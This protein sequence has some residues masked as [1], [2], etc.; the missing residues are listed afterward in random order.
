MANS[1]LKDPPEP[2]PSQANY[3]LKQKPKEPTNLQK[4]VLSVLNLFSRQ[5]KPLAELHF[6][7][8]LKLQ[9]TAIQLLNQLKTI[10]DL[11]EH[12]QDEELHSY[13]KTVICTLDQN[14]ASIH[15]MTKEKKDLAR[16]VKAYELYA[17]WISEARPWIALLSGGHE[18]D[19]IVKISAGYISAE[20]IER[21]IRSIRNYPS[22]QLA[23]KYRSLLD[24][25]LVIPLRKLEGLK[26]LPEDLSIKE[27]N[28]WKAAVDHS[29]GEYYD[30]ALKI[31]DQIIREHEESAD[32]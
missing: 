21:D 31:I 13:I 19:V 5:E 23:E 18:R 11:Y 7:E 22:Y 8:V 10:K 30:E 12:S 25:A 27:L 15:E 6:V 24:K 9:E 3:P 14:V 20:R 28:N 26:Y 29:R 4:I 17:Q 16:Q 32:R 1:T 2:D